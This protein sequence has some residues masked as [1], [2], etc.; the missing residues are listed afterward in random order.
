LGAD[1]LTSLHGAI[2]ARVAAHLGATPHLIH[3]APMG[4]IPLT[5]SGKVQRQATKR[6]L[7]EQS[8]ASY[9]RSRASQA[10]E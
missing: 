8:L 9:Q 7:L 4:A 2:V 6:A 10:E 3:F 5:T 1:E